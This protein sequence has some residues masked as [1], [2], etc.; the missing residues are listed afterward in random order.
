M[1]LTEFPHFCSFLQRST[2]VSAPYGAPAQ[3]L[4][5]RSV[6]RHT[7]PLVFLQ[8]RLHQS[9]RLACVQRYHLVGRHRYVSQ[10]PRAGGASRHLQ[11]VPSQISATTRWSVRLVRK[12]SRRD[13][14]DDVTATDIPRLDVASSMVDDRRLSVSVVDAV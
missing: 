9:L 11:Y 5:L 2:R 7:Q 12:L 1:L 8:L 14:H 13:A 6:L 4:L 3:V 10:L